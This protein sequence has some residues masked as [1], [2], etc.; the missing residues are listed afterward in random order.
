MKVKVPL[1]QV[2]IGMYVCGFGGSWFDHPFWKAKFLLQ[3]EE[4]LDRIRASGVRHVL[5]DDEL[6]AGP[7]PAGTESATEAGRVSSPP[8]A[9]SPA[10]ARR[11]RAS[12]PP[13]RS[14]SDREKARAVFSR[15]GKIIRYVFDGARLGRAVRIADVAAIVDDVS[16]TVKRQ[17]R[18]LLDVVRLKKKDEYTYLHSVAVCALML[19]VARQLGKSEEEIREYGLAGLL[20]DL[21]KMGVSDDIL[22]KPGRLTDAEFAIMRGHPDHGYDLLVDAP[23]SSEVVLDVCRLHHEKVDGTGYPLRLKG[24]DIPLAARLGAICDVYDALTSH[25]AYKQASSPMEAVAAMWSWDGH[26]DRDLLFKFMQGISVFPT[27]MLVQLRSNRL[28]V[29]L[30]PGRGKTQLHVLA[31]YSTR[32]R[33]FIGREVVKMKSNLAN[34]GILSLAEPGA[35]GFENWDRMYAALLAGEPVP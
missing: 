35:W 21:G 30:E 25:R 18:T 12:P 9:S 1:D 33:S 17:P 11:P 31:F 13:A 34:D 8:R 24:A 10:F 23:G 3:S 16:E 6:G 29:V 32:E 4:D 7:E 15:S 26:F 5:I 20:H 14:Q 2:R 28:G 19:H 27:G 22:N